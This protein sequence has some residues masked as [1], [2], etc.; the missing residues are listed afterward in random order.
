MLSVHVLSYI[1]VGRDLLVHSKLTYTSLACR[2][3]LAGYRQKLGPESAWALSHANTTAR[4]YPRFEAAWRRAW[5]EWKRRGGERLL[6]DDAAASSHGVMESASLENPRV[7]A[8]AGQRG[9]HANAKEAHGAHSHG[10]QEKQKNRSEMAELRQYPSLLLVILRV[11]G[12][13]LLHAQLLKRAHDIIQFLNP[14]W[15]KCAP[16]VLV[17]F[18]MFFCKSSSSV[19]YIG[20]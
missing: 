11:F 1:H 14:I 16:Y 18:L 19:I 5:D 3:V 8:L 4:N 10:A 9:G 17:Y 7:R 2:L 20:L 13:Q 12:R 6:R 15:L